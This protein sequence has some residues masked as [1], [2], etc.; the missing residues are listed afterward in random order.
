MKFESDIP[1]NLEEGVIESWL[2]A[3]EETMEIRL[4][5]DYRTHMLRYNGGVPIK[6]NYAVFDEDIA[7]VLVDETII[8]KS[9]KYL[10]NGE[11]SLDMQA[12]WGGTD[13]IPKGIDIG[14]TYGG[15]LMMSLATGGFG[16]IY[17]MFSYGEP[18]KIA[19]SWTEFVSYLIDEDLDE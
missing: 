19:N 13:Y 14:S 6:E 9:F 12:R 8:I 15:I 1:E 5:E 4:P 3:F 2:V 18:Q 16:S 10:D 7:D 17:H 11:G